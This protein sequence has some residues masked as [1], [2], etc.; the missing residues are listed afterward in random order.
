HNVFQAV[1]VDVHQGDVRGRVAGVQG[2][3][4][5]RRAVEPEAVGRLKHHLDAVIQGVGQDEVVA[6]VAGEVGGG[7]A[8]RQLHGREDRA[9]ADGVEGG[10]GVQGHRVDD[11]AGGGEGRVELGIGG[12][13]GQARGGMH[14]RQVAGGSGGVED[15]GGGKWLGGIRLA[16]TEED[17]A[18]TVE[19]D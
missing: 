5:R 12:G 10:E 14:Q 16:A 18:R 2:E 17:V 15:D 7:D 1:L 8:R 13:D 6:P 4:K 19:D 3:R 9:A 11:L